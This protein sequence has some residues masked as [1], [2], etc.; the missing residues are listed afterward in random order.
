MSRHSTHA[1]RRWIMHHAAK[2]R[3]IVIVF[4]GSSLRFPTRWRTIPRVHHPQRHKNTLCRIF[5]QRHAGNPLHERS[6]RDEVDVGIQK[7][8]ARRIGGLFD[9]RHAVSRLL[10]FPAVFEIKIFPQPRIVDEKLAHRD[11]FLSVHGKLRKILPDGIVQL[12][13]AL[14]KKPHHAGCRR[15]HFRQRRQIENR[16]R[17]HRLAA[18][19]YRAGAVGFAV[20]HLSVMPHQQ[21]SARNLTFANRTL[22]NRIDNRE[23]SSRFRANGRKACLAFGLLRN[24]ADGGQSQQ[25]QRSNCFRQIHLGKHSKSGVHLHGRTWFTSER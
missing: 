10:P 22:N 3:V 11:V 16:F 2:H 6:Q 21:Y 18:G 5:V 14:L 4:R 15:N 9:E 19:L 12:D 13:L 25:Q 8:R 23:R 1:P 7:A 20:D 17:R 24:A